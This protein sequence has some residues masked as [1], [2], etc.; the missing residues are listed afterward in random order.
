MDEGKGNYI[1]Y[2]TAYNNFYKIPGIWEAKSD[3]AL[4]GYFASMGMIHLKLIKQASEVEKVKSHITG[5]QTW[6]NWMTGTNLKYNS[7][8][9]VTL[10]VN[11]EVPTEGINI[12]LK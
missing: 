12:T 4:E 11:P 2:F 9:K 3:S 7:D 1:L 10:T 5:C 8:G 6:A